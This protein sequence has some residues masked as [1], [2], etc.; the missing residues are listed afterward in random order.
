MS[1]GL[2]MIHDTLDLFAHGLYGAEKSE[3]AEAAEK[4]L[5]EAAAV[6]AQSNNGNKTA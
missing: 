2:K 4:D 5:Q 1:E 3:A 6:P